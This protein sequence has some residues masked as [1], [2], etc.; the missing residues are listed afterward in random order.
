[1]ADPLTV[2]TT[3]ITFATFI[4][5]LIE[6]G[7][8][9]RRSIEKVSENRRQIRNLT[10]D[11][12]RTLADLANLSRAHE[13]VFQTPELLTALAN[14]KADMLH[15]LSVCGKINTVE[16]SH[17]LRGFRSQIKVWMKRDD[18]ER[19]IDRLKGHVNKCYLQFTAFSAARIEHASLRV[20]HTSLRVEQRLI[21]NNVDNQVRLRRLE[22]MMARMLLET[23]FG[24]N[25][26]NQT[27]EI[28]ASDTTH[29][30]L[31]FQYLST[32]ALR[33]TDI[34]QER[35]ATSS[36]TFV[37][38]APL[39]DGTT[40]VFSPPPASAKHI[41]HKILGFAVKL[42]DCP[43]AIPLESIE[44]IIFTL[45]QELEW[46]GMNS[47]GT[48]CDLAITRIL[49]LPAR[50]AQ[51]GADILPHLILS[52]SNLSARYQYQLRWDLATQ[53]SQ[54][55]LDLCRWLCDISPDAD[56]WSLFA[57]TSNT[58]SDNLRMTGQLEAAIS[59]SQEAVVS[60]RPIIAQIIK[61]VPS[62]LS[63]WTAAEYKAARSVQTFF[64]FARALSHA[65]DRPLEAHQAWKEGFQAMLRLPGVRDPSTGI[66]I[67]LFVDQIC[68][69]A[70][71]GRFTL[72]MLAEVVIL[73]RNLGRIWGE[74]YS[75]RF[76][77]M[78][79]A[80]A[81]YSQQNHISSLENIRLFLEPSWTSSPPT[82]VGW[83]TLKSY[84][85]DFSAYGGVIEDAVR[86]FYTRP[87]FGAP[88]FVVIRNIFITHFHQASIVLRD[89][90]TSFL[91]GFPEEN[92]EDHL[93][94]F[95]AGICNTILFVSPPQKK[96]LLGIMAE[97]VDQFRAIATA[98]PVSSSSQT[99]R[100]LFTTS[101]DWYSWA[102]WAVGMPADA[103]E[104]MEE[105]I[106]YLRARPS[107]ID[108]KHHADN[109]RYWSL[110]RALIFYEMTRIPE[111]ITAIQE[112]ATVSAVPLT[113]GRENDQVVTLHLL[114]QI[115]ILHRTGQDNSAFRF[116]QTETI[117]R[118]LE[119]EGVNWDII[120]DL[121]FHFLLVD[122][123]AVW[124]WHIG[125]ARKARQE[126]ERALVT[127]RQHVDRSSYI[128]QKS[129]ANQALTWS[130]IRFSHS[131]KAVHMEHEA[132]VAAQEAVSIYT[133]NVQN[134]YLHHNFVF[135]IRPQELGA[136]A[137]HSL[138]LCLATSG[139]LEEALSKAEKATELYR[140]LIALAPR[141]LPNL[142][143]S[144]QNL[145][146]LLWSSDRRDESV[147]ACTEAV[148]ILRQVSNNEDYFL[149][150]LAEV[151]E[152]L[153]RYLSEKGDAGG[154]TA[155]IAEC[156]EVSRK[157]RLLPRQ[158]SFKDHDVL[159]DDEDEVWETA[160]ES[161]DEYHDLYTD[162]ELVVGD[163]L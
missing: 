78:L 86:A 56:Y 12:L 72:A 27:V 35:V 50:T 108:V 128:V 55:A 118:K 133:L 160:T 19:A 117:V 161:E 163:I 83:G 32:Q 26:M 145:A 88:G 157:I 68:V 123:A 80:Y 44:D 98:S 76:L 151:L 1:M 130:L 92:L 36:A 85:D 28:I 9:I 69:A 131:L 150:S 141:H 2:T 39:W 101:L 138:S 152:W 91:G 58:H 18:V 134:F 93:I 111:A 144:L 70:E 149:P 15:V 63:R 156:T 79:D 59:L 22:A 46:Y 115:H 125:Q 155:A 40:L 6:V 54:Q 38:E 97:M 84:V 62:G 53:M 90:V 147:V 100:Q 10:D 45:G 82:S 48:A 11:I 34:L 124:E 67:D 137:F 87:W 24:Q 135:I 154:A 129:N 140:E 17:G 142:A 153:G 104:V 60:C 96:N 122:C 74:G 162:E 8:S 158:L 119:E 47:E 132:L 5:D 146:S 120:G 114:I 121:N 148:G 23:Q 21:V 116:L 16:S 13:D 139:Q 57:L 29:Q 159:S 51:F 25:V 109:L 66:D 73:F 77:W 107:M 52:Y 127:C 31:E 112:A 20:E 49:R 89:L 4:K 42:S 33:L 143:G 61:A 43:T 41:L 71:G 14:L 81:Y 105:A 103:L 30:T 75:Q 113:A 3:I 64:A 37:S 110:L 126:A 102:L 106:Q 99:K 7:Q 95:F 136:N 94:G 65:V